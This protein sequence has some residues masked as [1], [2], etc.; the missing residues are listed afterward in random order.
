MKKIDFGA[1]PSTRPDHGSQD[2]WV[3]DRLTKPVEPMKR[4]TI[5]VPLSLHQ[6]VKSQCAIRGENMAKVVRSLLED[7]FQAH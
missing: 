2:K 3:T 5:D 7:H 6:A 1:K 4:L